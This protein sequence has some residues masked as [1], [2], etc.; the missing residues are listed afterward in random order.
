MY[1]HVLFFVCLLPAVAFAQI[2][3][4]TKKPSTLFKGWKPYRTLS[5]GVQAG[6]FM[7]VTYTGG[8]NDFS[9]WDAGFGYGATVRKQVA[10]SFGVELA[11]YRGTFS[12]NNKSEP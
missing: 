4:S 6:G 7:P 11:V 2:Q 3:D 1:K 9:N 10:H 12:G 5:V 8:T